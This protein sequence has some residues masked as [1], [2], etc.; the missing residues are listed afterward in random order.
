MDLLSW[1]RIIVLH[2]IN[3]QMAIITRIQVYRLKVHHIKYKTSRTVLTKRAY[4]LQRVN[5]TQAIITKIKI[6]K[7]K[8]L[9]RV[10]L[11]LK[12]KEL[13]IIKIAN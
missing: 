9:L 10:N 8:I 2:K 11:Q 6:C 5:S 13:L 4:K 3:L 7:T 12:E 1:F